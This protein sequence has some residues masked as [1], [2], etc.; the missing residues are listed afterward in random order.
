L[1]FNDIMP[2]LDELT[3][4]LKTFC[5]A[6]L[7][8]FLA[9]W[10]GLDNPYWCM[11]TA[12]IVAQPLTGAMRSKALY[13][14]IGTFCGGTAAVILVPNLVNAPVLL[15]I[16]LAIWIGLCL[17]LS[18]LDR[19]PRS[20]LFML[21]GYTAGIIGLPSVTDPGHIFQ[22]AL[23]R[24]EEISLGIAC[25][26]VVGTIVFPRPLGP[27][28]ASRIAAWVKPGADWAVA[29]LRG[30][31]EDTQLRL[32]RR[33][34]AAEA[35]DIA[36]MTTQL[37]F[38][39]S[40][41]KAATEHVKRLRIYVLSLMPVLSSLGDRVAQLRRLGGIPPALQTVLDDCATWIQSGDPQEAPA[42]HAR[43]AAL[44]HEPMRSWDAILRQCLVVRLTELVSI[45]RH[46]RTIRRHV[47]DGAP[48]PAE[49]PMEMDFVATSH[50]VR[51]HGLAI[52][53]A[54]A[55]GLALL[56]VCG[57]WI[58]TSWTAGAG[59]A[60]IVAVACSF[61][62]AQDDPAPAIAL[63]LRNAVIVTV[64]AGIYEFA[65]L[66]R[67]ETFFEL[68]LVLAS[69]AMVIGVLVSRPATFGT[70]MVMG[71]F[72]STDLALGNGYGADFALY[73]NNAVGLVAG[74]S[75]ALVI[76]R[77]LRSVGA[78]FSA[79]RLLRAGWKDIA[80]AA[81]NHETREN[82]AHL[83][84]IMLDRLGLLMPRLAAVSPGAD[85]AAAD[86]LLDLRVG[87]NVLGLQHA[88]DDLPGTARRNA[89]AVLTGIA[90]HYRGNPLQSPPPVLLT[91]IDATIRA[92]ARDTRPHGQALMLLVG[93]RSI[94]FADAP[95]PEVA[96]WDNAPPFEMA[97]E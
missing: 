18:L 36:M 8:L 45:V 51:D 34:L 9:F 37:A 77:L 83:T 90:A 91:R 94:L 6:M 60:V 52:L 62:A 32:D 63:M 26:T 72:G 66:P 41:L 96:A 19:T 12:Y 14:F 22:T 54:L 57:F 46:S 2:T 58:E 68:A 7:A 43:I 67:V 70:G 53:S 23:T 95:P 5:G 73:V 76:T 82:R 92:V 56:L 24:V 47:V 16:A 39:T 31:A 40:H 71:A 89:A 84:G 33:R 64:A 61:F 79:R 48:A 80:A 65:I 49:T 74:V 15:C 27:V 38:D 29:A 42:L 69:A 3:F 20:Y 93:L 17:Y 25:T 4:A 75:A 50:Q 21:A 88:L 28:L 13:R 44:A 81:D 97:A 55:A 86:V 85:I 59:A 35:T 30:G 10:L 11:A 1:G 78:A 87:L